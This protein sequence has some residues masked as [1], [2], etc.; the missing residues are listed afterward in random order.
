MES[1]EEKQKEQESIA[2]QRT[3]E[4]KAHPL[5][6]FVMKYKLTR[7]IKHTM[8]DYNL[9]AKRAMGMIGIANTSMIAA[10]FLSNAGYKLELFFF[11][12]LMVVTYFVLVA[13]GWVETR[14]GLF[15]REQELVTNEQPQIVELLERV[16]RIEEK[17]N[18]GRA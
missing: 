10:L 13:M 16:K 2:K 18:E 7:A 12:M 5:E 8:A 6:V 17:L 3:L 9:F 15:R 4:A 1:Q 11:F 14:S